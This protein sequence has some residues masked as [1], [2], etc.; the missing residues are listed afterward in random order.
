[1]IGSKIHDMSGLDLTAPGITLAGRIEP[2]QSPGVLYVDGP[3]TIADESTLHIE[4]GGTTPGTGENL[5]DQLRTESE[6]NILSNVALDVS[7]FGD[8]VPTPG[9]SFVIISRTG[10]SGTF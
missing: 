3:V 10:G 8:F 9:D 2:G 1:I 6:V 5:H 4:L 7:L